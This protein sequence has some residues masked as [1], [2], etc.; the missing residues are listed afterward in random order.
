[1]CSPQHL[2]RHPFGRVP[3]LGFVLYEAQAILR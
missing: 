1:L 2:V 3:V